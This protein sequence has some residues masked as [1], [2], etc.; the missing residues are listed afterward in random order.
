MTALGEAG[1][2]PPLHLTAAAAA[3]QHPALPV[4]PNALVAPLVGAREQQ[5]AQNGVIAD[6]RQA[7]AALDVGQEAESCREQPTR[8]SALTAAAAAA[9]AALAEAGDGSVSDVFGSSDDEDDGLGQPAS[10]A[11]LHPRRLP[12]TGRPPAAATWPVGDQLLHQVSLDIAAL[13][14]RNVALQ[15]EVDGMSEASSSRHLSPGAQL[16]SGSDPAHL[17]PAAAG[18][19]GKWTAGGSRTLLPR[20]PDLSQA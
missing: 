18:A 10:G 3:A 19:G 13:S 16:S 5:T 8:P 14:A 17:P 1:L 20:T 11:P 9:V 12:P 6:L 4:G 2:A 15:Q 7:M